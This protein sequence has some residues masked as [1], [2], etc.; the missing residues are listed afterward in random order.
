MHAHVDNR[1]GINFGDQP[2]IAGR[3]AL[4][5]WNGRSLHRQRNAHESDCGRA[6]VCYGDREVLHRH[7]LAGQ[8]T[9]LIIFLSLTSRFASLIGASDE[10]VGGRGE[11]GGHFFT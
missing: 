2:D 9:P 4:K 10:Q 1:D 5:V 11:E 8:S 6:L 7:G 3:W